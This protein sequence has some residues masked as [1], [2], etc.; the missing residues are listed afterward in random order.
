MIEIANDAYLGDELVMRGGTCLHKLFTGAMH[1]YSEDLDY[2]RRS[3]GGIRDLTAAVTAIG[4]R[5][6]MQVRTRVG[7]QPRVYLRSPFENGAGVMRIKVEMNTFERSPARPPIRVHHEVASSWFSGS[8]EVATFALPELVATKLR[9]L[10]QRSKGRDLF[11]L[12]LAITHLGV[13]PA[14]LAE[15]FAPYRPAGY[16]ARRAELNLR[17]K[18]ADPTFRNDL[19]PLVAAWPDRYDIDA[20]AEIL[21]AD[22]LSVL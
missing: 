13:E 21:I 17:E 2:V 3:G 7:Q 12:W 16:T 10:F 11:D 18:L 9:A 20:A 4:E 5:L 8:A 1:R 22:V 6:G 14:A 15:C 19:T